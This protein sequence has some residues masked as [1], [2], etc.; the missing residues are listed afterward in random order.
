[1]PGGN[2]NASRQ[3]RKIVEQCVAQRAAAGARR[4]G[5]EIAM[6]DQIAIK[7][8]ESLPVGGGDRGCQRLARRK[9]RIGVDVAPEFPRNVC[10]GGKRQRQCPERLLERFLA[11]DLPRK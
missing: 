8:L 4:I 6:I 7:A 10:F 3:Q 2:F 1:M 9:D 11:G 5:A